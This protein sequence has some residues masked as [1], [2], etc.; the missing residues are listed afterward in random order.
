M[1]ILRNVLPTAVLKMEAVY[2]FD[3]LTPIYQTV[4]VT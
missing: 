4:K 2:S 1:L 3:I